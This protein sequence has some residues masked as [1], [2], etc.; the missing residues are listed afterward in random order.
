MSDEKT[1]G[2]KY[3]VSNG[4]VYD[5]SRESIWTRLGLNAESFKPAP[6]STKGRVSHGD[7][8][9]HLDIH[10]HGMLQQKMQPRHLQMIAA[11]GAIGTGLFVGTGG[12]LASGGPAGIM[13]AWILMG[14]ML[15]NVCGMAGGA[16]YRSRR[17]SA[18][19]RSCTRSTAA[20][21]RWRAGSWTR[22]WALRSGRT[23]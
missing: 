18:S 2:G 21:S 17:R 23:T 5:P 6:A 1:A 13:L 4:E 8:P 12:A 3:A 11:G 19:C 15:V 10:D 14:C 9:E 22:R 16:N 20:S 7:I